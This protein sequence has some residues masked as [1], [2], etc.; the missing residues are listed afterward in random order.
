[1]GQPVPLTAQRERL[2][3]ENNEHFCRPLFVGRLGGIAGGVGGALQQGP[4][5]TE[6]RCW[7]CR[8]IGYSRDPNENARDWGQV[9]P[10]GRRS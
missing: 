6:P 9:V 10:F 2:A 4:A 8:A 7:W 5:L 1:M 3:I